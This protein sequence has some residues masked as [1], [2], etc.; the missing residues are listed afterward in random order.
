MNF[1]EPKK[2]PD[3]RYFVNVTGD[4]SS[5]RVLKQLNNVTLNTPFAEG[6]TVTI[7]LPS[8]AVSQIKEVDLEIL[9][10]AEINSTTWFQKELKSQTLDAAFT[11]SLSDTCMNISKMKNQD[12]K[13]YSS[14][15]EIVDPTTFMSDTV[16]DVVIELVGIWFMKKTFGTGWRLVQMR[17][18]FLPKPKWNEQYLFQDEEQQQEGDEEED[19]P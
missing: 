2:I 19:Y 7:S 12:V 11:K 6:D 1:S 15:K 4:S 5:G 14:N 17:E 16:C 18:K 8:A 13:A 10:G 3:G 9:R